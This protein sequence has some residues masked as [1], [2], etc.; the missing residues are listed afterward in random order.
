MLILFNS[1]I[2]FLRSPTTFL[3]G[4]CSFSRLRLYWLSF[5]VL[6]LAAADKENVQQR[7]VAYFWQVYKL[8]IVGIHPMA[9][10]TRHIPSV[11]N[12][13]L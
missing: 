7:I 12:A 13:R 10:H 4:E 5:L 6:L 3:P 9:K 2:S 11:F 8:T 1:S